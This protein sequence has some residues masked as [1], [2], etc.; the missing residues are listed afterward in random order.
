MKKLSIIV[1]GTTL[2]FLATGCGSRRECSDIVSR[3]YIHKYGYVVAKEDWEKHC[4]P[5]QVITT[6]REGVTITATYENGLLHGACTH[7]YPHSQTVHHFFLYNQ[8]DLAKELTYNQIGMPIQ[9]RVQHSVQRY[10]LTQ[11]YPDGTPMSI[12]NYTGEELLDGEYLTQMNEVEAR[13]DHGTGERIYRNPNGALIAR[14]WIEDGY[15]VKRETFY[16]TG[17]PETTAYYVKNRLSGERTVY[18]ETGEP[19]AIEEWLHGNLHGKSSYFANGVKRTEVYYLNG[20]KNGPERQFLDGEAVEQECYWSNNK[21]H[22]PCTFFVEGTPSHVDWYY[23][24]QQVSEKKYE[25]LSQLDQII[26]QSTV[27]F[28]DARR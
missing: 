21:R 5:G 24:G 25:K 6:T 1:L 22:G 23:A 14:D 9:E 7:T 8:G 18:A 4:Y 13:V 10:T 28:N 11:W 26:T 3:R 19:L 16:L 17:L 27:E 15:I 20:A 2:G 12:E